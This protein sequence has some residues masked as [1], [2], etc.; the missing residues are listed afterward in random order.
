VIASSAMA[1][2]FD[3]E[4]P[5]TIASYI[6]H[7]LLKPDASRQEVRVLCEEALLHKFYGVCVNPYHITHAREVLR[8]TKIQIC[9]VVGF[10]FGATE[11]TVK[12]FEAARSVNLGAH[13]LDMV[14]NIAALKSGDHSFVEREILSVVRA[15]EG[16][17]VKVIIETGLLDDKEKKLACSLSQQAG[18][19][20][21]KTCTGFNAGSAT[22]ADVR[23]MK[24]SIGSKM[25][26]KASGGIQDFNFAAELIEAG[27]SRIGTS[28]GV[29][30][31]KGSHASGRTY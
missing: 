4:R 31:T 28:H 3:R 29:A 9:T 17:I 1:L 15:A 13:E 21:V 23:L 10:P 18:A 24:A 8:N 16:K 2:N 14:I 22:A 19:Q 25:Q 27:A 6:D 26:V 5:E 12:A 11:A 20:F 7:T 30:L